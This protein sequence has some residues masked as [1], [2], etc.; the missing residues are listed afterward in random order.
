LNAKND[1]DAVFECDGEILEAASI[2]DAGSEI[3]VYVT[4]KGKYSGETIEGTYTVRELKA[5]IRNISTAVVTVDPVRYTGKELK[6]DVFVKLK[7][8]T[9][10]TEGTDYVVESYANNIN[11]SKAAV[12]IIRGTGDYSGTKIQKFT[13]L[14]AAADSWWSN[15]INS[16][17]WN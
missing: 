4:G 1:Y 15:V 7:D 14:K 3:T 6:P 17:A 13:I 8:G 9:L 2:A 12:V 5:D 16:L 11:P 10:L